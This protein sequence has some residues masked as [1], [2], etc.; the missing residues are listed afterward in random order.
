MT[1][2]NRGSVWRFE[3]EPNGN[4]FMR[5]CFISNLGIHVARKSKRLVGFDDA[6]LKGDM[7]KRVVHLLLLQKSPTTTSLR[8]GFPLC[9][10]RGTITGSGFGSDQSGMW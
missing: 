7:N 6:H 8:L 9:P 10:S 4:T 3:K 2:R 5:V 1:E